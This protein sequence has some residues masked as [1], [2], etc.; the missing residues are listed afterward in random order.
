[1]FLGNERIMIK[2]KTSAVSQYLQTHILNK[3]HL[4]KQMLLQ[5]MLENMIPVI[6]A[7]TEIILIPYG[8]SKF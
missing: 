5:L 7:Y 6:P 2:N 3:S 8:C 1:M 4:Y